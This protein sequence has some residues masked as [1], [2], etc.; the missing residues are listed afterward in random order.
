MKL[1]ISNIAWNSEYDEYMYNYLNN[2]GFEGLEVAPTRLVPDNPYSNINR[3]VDIVKN[4][5]DKYNLEISSM[6]SI[7]FGR[8]EN[9]F[10]S[11]GNRDV[12]IAYTDKAIEYAKSIK[13]N[14][15]VFGSPKNRNIDDINKYNIAIDFFRTLG[16]HA[17]QNNVVIAFEPNPTIYNTNF[18]NYTTQAINFVKEVNSKGLKVNLDLG[19]AIWNNEDIELILDDISIINHIHISE[20]FLE[21]IKHRKIHEELRNL[22]VKKGYDNYVSIEMKNSDNIDIVKSAVS[23]INEVMR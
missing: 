19:T 2:I 5:Q 23:Y 13:C 9:I 20:P 17:E 1:S 4:I 8:V 12:L 3:A 15:L 14:N 11:Q 22:L 21:P 7:W 18:I 16:E 10:T 6:Q